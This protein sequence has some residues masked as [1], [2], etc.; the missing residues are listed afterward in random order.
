LRA[1]STLKDA[2]AIVEVGSYCGRSTVV[3]GSVLQS[4]RLEN[5]RVYAIDPHDGKLGSLDQ[6]IQ[7]VTPSLNRFQRNIAAAGLEAFVEPI[8]SHP[9]DV[10]WCKPICFLFIDG[11]HDYVSVARD[12]FH[13]QSWVASGG[14]VAFHDYAPYY[15][16]VMTFVNEI[17]AGGGYERVYLRG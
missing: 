15:P 12:F 5:V 6:E 11:L 2:T 1:V 10:Q 3:L 14:Y 4:L 16:G 17:L 8:C 9:L 7:Q 13:F